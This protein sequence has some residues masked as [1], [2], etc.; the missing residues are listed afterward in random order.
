MSQ[1]SDSVVAGS[2]GLPHAR[3]AQALARRLDR[4][5]DVKAPL[6]ARQ[7]EGVRQNIG[8]I[9]QPNSPSAVSRLVEKPEQALQAVGVDGG[10][11]RGV[12]ND[13]ANPRREPLV[14]GS[15][16][17][18]AVIPSQR[19]RDGEGPGG[20]CSTIEIAIVTANF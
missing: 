4:L 11:V 8:G 2:R 10:Q 1:Q 17:P 5:M 18:V 20:A 14:A 13:I 15:S 7:M 6:Q 3:A 9:H 16:K 12:E 19:A